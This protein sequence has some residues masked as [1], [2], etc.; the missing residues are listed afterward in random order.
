MQIRRFKDIVAVKA[1]PDQ[2]WGF[3]AHNLEVAEVSEELWASLSTPSSLVSQSELH[4]ELEAWNQEVATTTQD[5]SLET[6][7]ADKNIQKLSL[8][9]AQVCN[10][11]CT[12]CAAG[13]DGTYGSQTPKINLELAQKQIS[14]FLSLT[15]AKVFRL[16]FIGGEP[17][18]YPGVLRELCTY[19]QLCVAGRDIELQFSTTTNGTRINADI[20]KLLAQFHFAVTI[21]LDGDE[22][23]NNTSRPL[24]TKMDPSGL[25]STQQTLLGLTHLQ[26]VRGELAAL[27]IN[28]VFGAHNIQV[29]ASYQY[30]QS[31]NLDWDEISLLYSNN[32]KDDT[33]SPIYVREMQ[34]VADL[35]YSRGGITALSK[36]KQFQSYLSRLAAQTRIHSY[37][38]AGKSL[39]QIDT[40]GDLY[41]C[42]WFMNDKNEKV[43]HGLELNQHKLQAY[44]KSF[45]ELNNCNSCWA[46]HLCGGGCLAVHKAKT[47]DRHSKDPHFCSRTRELAATAIHFYALTLNQL[48]NNQSTSQEEEIQNEKH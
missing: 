15:T 1:A 39:L 41:T 23:V 32:E 45:I 19:A 2:V 31:L 6:P 38:G 40:R 27:K 14:H 22:N 46:R 9:I 25:S 16:Q 4:T 17:L 7:F 42:N 33:L 3:H 24:K 43:G 47:G 44:E 35:A 8:N 5:A 26:N 21:S 18:L 30:L 12:Y 11:K 48:Q 34:A 36:I 20:A 28:S 29:L 37:C 10:L 13:G